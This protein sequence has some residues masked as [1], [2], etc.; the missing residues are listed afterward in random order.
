MSNKNEV[1]VFSSGI[2]RKTELKM[3]LGIDKMLLKPVDNTPV[4]YVVGWGRKE[5]TKQA[6]AYADKNK[7]DYF[8]LEDGFLHSMGQGVLGASSCSLVKDREGI[9]YDATQV[10]D[11][12]KMLS[13]E[14]NKLFN[15]A[16]ILRAKDAIQKITLSNISKYNNASFQLDDSIFHSPQIVLVVDQTA[17]DMSLQYGYVNENTFGE[18]LHAALKDYPDAQIVIKTHPDVIV[19]KKKGNIKLIDLDARVTVISSSINPLHLL[20]KVDVVYVATSQ[21]GFEALMLGKQVICFG[22]PF[23]AGWGLT[24]DRA[25]KTLAVWGRRNKNRSLEELFAASYIHYP[26]YM[27][28]DTTALC[29]LEDIIDYFERQ[30]NNRL[31]IKGR[32]FCFGFTRWKRNYIKAFLPVS[33]KQLFFVTSTEQVRKHDFNDSDQIICWA[34]KDNTETYELASQFNSNVWHV[35]DGFIRSTGLGTDL[36]APASLVLDKLG[37]YYDPNFAGDLEKLLQGKTFS[38][39]ELERAESLRTSLLEN[40]LSKYNLG[41]KFSKD[42][43]DAKLKQKVILIPGQVEDDASI[44]KG[45]VDVASNSALIIATK[46]KEPKAYLIYK[47]H[48][49]VVSG[50]RKGKVEKSILEKYCDLVLQDAS[51]TDCL[52]V[53]DEVHTMTSLV[54]FEGLLRK[55]TVVCYGLPF[56]SNWGLTDDRHNILRRTRKLKLEELVAGTLIDYPR[57]INWETGGFTT[58]EIIVKQLKEKIEKQGGKQSNQ[59]FWPLRKIRKFKNVLLGLYI[60]ERNL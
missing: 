47:P 16:S 23:Y 55:L 27:H 45:C 24:E 51:I 30:I 5:N 7:L 10:S 18:M 21:M 56:Y 59:V 53:V 42:L 48:P 50:N 12:E 37:I 39:D 29:A 20:K 25:D 38:K 6:R 33:E 52:A 58:P 43:L 28:P 46:E 8:S 17:G 9:Y 1:A 2:I 19:G 3:L 49:D 13:E 11:L 31:E 26:Y 22:V 57:Y 32:L 44:K 14:N 40:E 36:T 34:S 4:R 60:R 54:G 35:E 15:E 41:V